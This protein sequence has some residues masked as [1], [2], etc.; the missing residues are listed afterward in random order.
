MRAVIKINPAPEVKPLKIKVKDSVKL[1]SGT[2]KTVQHWSEVNNCEMTFNL[3]LPEDRINHQRNEP[4]PVLYFLAGLSC[5]QD[6]APQK[7]A[8][9][10]YAQKYKIAVVFPDTSPRNTGL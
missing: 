10:S 9:A 4:F 6:N 3:F 8:F 2:L 1:A 7:S 5:T